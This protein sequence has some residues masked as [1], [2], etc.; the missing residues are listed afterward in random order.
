[1]PNNVFA[2]IVEFQIFS[3]GGSLSKY[4]NREITG[5]KDDSIFVECTNMKW[6]L[7]LKF[8]LKK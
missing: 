6:E 5:E 8:E 2:N 4:L 1:M 3:V 7:D